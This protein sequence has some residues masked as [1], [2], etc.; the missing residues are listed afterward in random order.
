MLRW[1]AVA[2]MLALVALTGCGDIQQQAKVASP[3]GKPQV[4]GVGDTVLD[5]RLTE[6]LAEPI[7]ESRHLRSHS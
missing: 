4:A 6:S 7:R 3:T 2:A 5:M 1:G